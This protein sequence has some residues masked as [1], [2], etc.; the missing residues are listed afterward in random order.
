MGQAVIGSESKEVLI[1]KTV[2][3]CA[4]RKWTVH[5]CVDPFNKK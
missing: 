4:E 5:F 2:S 1:R 3:L